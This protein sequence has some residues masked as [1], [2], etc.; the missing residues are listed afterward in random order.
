VSARVAI[1]VPA[2]NEEENLPISLPGAVEQVGARN[3]YV[4]DDNSSDGT[5][6]EARRHTQNVY[7]TARGGKGAAVL[8]GIERFGL[9]DRYEGVLVLD[10][11]S[12]LAPGAMAR[13]EES[14]GPGVAAVIGHLSVLPFQ[15]GPI[16]AW[17]RHQYFYMTAVYLRGAVAYGGGVPVTPG[18]CTVYSTDALRAV[19]PDP[20]APTEDIDFC[21]QIHRKRLGKVRYASQARVETGVPVTLRDYVGQ[22]KR[23]DRG[24]HYATRKHRMPLGLQWVDLVAGLMT[25]EMFISWARYV[26]LGVLLLLTVWG[27]HF[28]VSGYDAVTIVALS[29][30]FDGVWLSLMGVVSALVLRD[31]SIALWLA[32]FPMFLCLD[33]VV[34]LYSAVTLD[35]GLDAVW[36]P[37]E[38]AKEIA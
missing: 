25:L 15:R 4:V 21:W 27:V 29:F 14:L 35:R 11:D 36:D 34:N 31:A 3:V 9:L 24:W 30:V 12:R 33:Q 18:F 32:L 7:S 1:L 26:L 22:I 19:D 37:P 23:W 28:T 8:A 2:H 10:A 17:R 13:Y 6:A 16:P 5:A 20:V 38:R